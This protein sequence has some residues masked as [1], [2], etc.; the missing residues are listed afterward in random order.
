MQKSGMG[1][2]GDLRPCHGVPYASD[3]VFRTGD[4]AGS[5]RTELEVPDLG[6]VAQRMSK[7]EPRKP[8]NAGKVLRGGYAY[9]SPISAEGDLGGIVR[10]LLALLL[11]DV[12]QDCQIGRGAAD[13][14]KPPVRTVDDTISHPT[15]TPN[16]ILR[17][18]SP[19]QRVFHRS[20]RHQHR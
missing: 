12:P 1:H 17:L 11:I 4:E 6:G 18:P 15:D 14:E 16:D 2:P 10:E 5:I 9:E 19:N 13:P 7:L 3:I 20:L 8:P